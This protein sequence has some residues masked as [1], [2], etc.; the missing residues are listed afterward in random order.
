MPLRTARIDQEEGA[1]HHE[2]DRTVY[3][4]ILYKPGFNNIEAADGGRRSTRLPRSARSS[5]LLQ[6]LQ[7]KDKVT[8]AGQDRT[9]EQVIHVLCHQIDRRAPTVAEHFDYI[10]PENPAIQKREYPLNGDHGDTDAQAT[11]CV[12]P[13]KSLL[14]AQ[15]LLR[16]NAGPGESRVELNP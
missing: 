4:Y 2:D 16:Q 6:A 5:A 10:R 13:R 15:T 1:P 11:A 14:A 8:V 12:Y 7:E 9:L 3:I